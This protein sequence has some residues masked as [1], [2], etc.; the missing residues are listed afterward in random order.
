MAD[1]TNNLESLFEQSC[2]LE[3]EL[4]DSLEKEVVAFL[5]SSLGGDI[6][7][8]VADDHRELMRVFRDMELVELTWCCIHWLMLEAP[9]TWTK[10]FSF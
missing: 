7:I 4:N 2:E 5:N 3:S 10:T 1:F 9:P 8:G 6:Y